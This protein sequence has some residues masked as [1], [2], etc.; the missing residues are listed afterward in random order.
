M[1]HG[2]YNIKH[3]VLYRNPADSNSEQVKTTFL[4]IKLNWPSDDPVERKLVAVS[5][6]VDDDEQF[7]Q[8]MT[9]DLVFML[10]VSLPLVV[11]AETSQHIY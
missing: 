10:L 9:V 3:S 8:S 7:V 2:V 4:K 11:E 6:A 5:G 1:D